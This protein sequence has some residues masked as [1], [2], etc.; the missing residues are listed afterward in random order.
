[1][2]IE[3]SWSPIKCPVATVNRQPCRTEADL[4]QKLRQVLAEKRGSV[5][6]AIHEPVAQRVFLSLAVFSPEELLPQD[7]G[8]VVG[9]MS[10]GSTTGTAR[11]ERP[12]NLG[13]SLAIT[14]ITRDSQSQTA[15]VLG[16]ALLSA[17]NKGYDNVSFGTSHSVSQH[18]EKPGAVLIWMQ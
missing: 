3:Q 6:I 4:Q 16:A 9:N 14:A 10:R 5:E 8:S 15:V 11:L 17:M 18:G 13:M 12:S 7:V 2:A 1:M